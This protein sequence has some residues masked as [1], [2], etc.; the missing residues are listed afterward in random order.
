MYWKPYPNN[1]DPVICKYL[2][3]FLKNVGRFCSTKDPH[4]EVTLVTKVLSS[5]EKG[6]SF[7]LL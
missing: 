3:F 4:N 7:N 6:C 1:L 2:Y 5:P